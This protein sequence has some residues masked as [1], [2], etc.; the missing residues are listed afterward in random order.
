[1]LQLGT[2][3]L[4]LLAGLKKL[5]AKLPKQTPAPENIMASKGFREFLK[6]AKAIQDQSGD[7]FM[8]L[9]NLLMACFDEA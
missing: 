2:N 6:R 1:M 4:Q 8:A 7:K 9:D 3:Q 5:F